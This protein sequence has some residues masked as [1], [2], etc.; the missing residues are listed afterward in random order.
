M[1]GDASEFAG[2]WIG[3][4]DLAPGFVAAARVT[5]PAGDCERDQLDRATRGEVVAH[6]TEQALRELLRAV[7]RDLLRAVRQRRV[8]EARDQRF[9][10]RH[11]VD[12]RRQ[13]Q[14][15]RDLIAHQPTHERDE[16]L[17]RGDLVDELVAGQKSE[18]SER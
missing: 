5:H 14:R 18:I 9:L 16:L 2:Q 15:R 13:F 6:G 11:D 7:H 8:A 12:S 17:V 1:R 3:N 4:H 10:V